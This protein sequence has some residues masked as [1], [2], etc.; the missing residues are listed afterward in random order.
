MLAVIMEKRQEEIATRQIAIME[1]GLYSIG[2][3]WK[4]NRE[5]IYDRY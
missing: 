1:K 4:F 3:G 5:E 2:K